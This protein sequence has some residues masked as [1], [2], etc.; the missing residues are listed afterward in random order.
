M[1]SAT[2]ASL[3]VKEALD[4]NPCPPMPGEDRHE[5]VFQLLLI[6]DS[7]VGKSCPPVRSA[8]DTY[9]ESY[10]STIGGDHAL[11]GSEDEEEELAEIKPAGGWTYRWKLVKSNS[12]RVTKSCGPK[13]KN[14]FRL[15]T[16]HML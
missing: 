14:D 10:L 2:A 9:T 15:S 11:C 3:A 13:R 12:R 5:Y 6:G 16:K 7:G 1:K 4:P 8:D